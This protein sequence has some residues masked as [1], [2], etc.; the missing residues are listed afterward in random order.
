MHSSCH[1]IN[2]GL[3]SRYLQSR[4]NCLSEINIPCQLFDENARGLARVF[5]QIALIETLLLYRP[6]RSMTCSRVAAALV[7]KRVAQLFWRDLPSKD[8]ATF[9]RGSPFDT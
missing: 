8:C 4:R 7:G 2:S 6:A 9:R 1:S 3:S 5:V